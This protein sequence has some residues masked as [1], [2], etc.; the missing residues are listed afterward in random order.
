M[1]DFGTLIAQNRD[2]FEYLNKNDR[3]MR[4]NNS[5][6]PIYFLFEHVE[7]KPVSKQ[8]LQSQT[9]IRG[10]KEL[11]IMDGMNEYLIKHFYTPSNKTHTTKS[12]ISIPFT[13]KY[14]L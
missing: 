13:I 3:R 2:S 7:N 1:A 4:F 10:Y 8:M 12:Y 11:V 6:D 14:K 9:G 5:Q